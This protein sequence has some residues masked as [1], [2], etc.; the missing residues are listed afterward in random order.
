M[1]D[2]GLDVRCVSTAAK[3]NGWRT[4]AAKHVP[5]RGRR[6]SIRTAGDA[7]V[8]LRKDRG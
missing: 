7:C 2:F 4:A 3:S 8:V 5:V 1:P 6:Y